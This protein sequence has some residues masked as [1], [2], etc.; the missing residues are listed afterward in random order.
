MKL[1]LILIKNEKRL[2]IQV[3]HPGIQIRYDSRTF[4]QLVPDAVRR[5]YAEQMLFIA[6]QNLTFCSHPQRKTLR[7][8]KNAG[9]TACVSISL[10]TAE[11]PY[12]GSASW[13]PALLPPIF[14]R[15]RK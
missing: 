12:S 6:E 11:S 14:T 5:I 1:S 8:G 2:L 3:Q 10:P 13:H 15:L 4:H 9:Q 7:N